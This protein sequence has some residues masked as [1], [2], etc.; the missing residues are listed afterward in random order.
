MCIRDSSLVG[1]TDDISLLHMVLIALLK[2]LNIYGSTAYRL[3]DDII[4]NSF[5]RALKIR[6]TSI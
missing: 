6:C 1:T 2:I 4:F 5:T 3:Q